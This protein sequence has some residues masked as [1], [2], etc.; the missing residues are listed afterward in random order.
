MSLLL[1]KPIQARVEIIFAGGGGVN[2]ESLFRGAYPPSPGRVDSGPPF[3]QV[4]VCVCVRVRV[5]V[6]V[7][8]CGFP[9]KHTH[10]TLF[11]GV[12]ISA[13]PQHNL[14]RGGSIIGQHWSWFSSQDTTKRKSLGVHHAGVWGGPFSGYLH[15]LQ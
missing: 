1:R 5:R 9:Q 3:K 7:C 8:V 11:G 2:R 10:T 14:N 13:G 12:L 15:R 6:C 4:C